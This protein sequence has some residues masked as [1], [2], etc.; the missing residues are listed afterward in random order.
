M[1]SALVVYLIRSQ[2]SGLTISSVTW[3]FLTFTNEYKVLKKEHNSCKILSLKTGSCRIEG[4]LRYR[5][6]RKYWHIMSG[7]GT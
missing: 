3:E 2:E 7:I 1:F 6:V 5:G 4:L